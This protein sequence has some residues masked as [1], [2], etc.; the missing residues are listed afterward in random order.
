MSVSMS[1]E[2]YTQCDEASAGYQNQFRKYSSVCEIEE[3]SPSETFEI[4]HGVPMASIRE[5]VEGS[6]FSFDVQNWEDSVYV[7]VG[8]SDSSMDALAWTLKHAVTPSTI[9]YL[10]HVFPETRYIPSPCKLSLD[11]SLSLSLSLSC[12]RLTVKSVH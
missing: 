1:E 10:V 2:T 5:E 8:K 7:A 12:W 11:L 6:L 4:N 9:V 3:E